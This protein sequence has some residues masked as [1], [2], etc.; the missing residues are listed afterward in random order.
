VNE[1]VIP[2]PAKINLFLE[3]VA[4][5]PDGFHEIESVLQLVDL[6]DEVRLC[7]RRDGIRLHVSGAELPEGR[8]NLAYRAA[9]AALETAGVSDGVEIR[10]VKRI[11]VGG[12]LGGGSS[13]AAA[14]LLGVSRL[15]DFRW[16]HEALHRLAGDLGSDVPFFLTDGVAVARGRGE[17]LTPL[18][19]WTPQWLVLANPGISISTGWAYGE[20]SSKLTGCQA[21][22]R[23][24]T[25]TA[26]RPLAWP[27]VWAF[28]RFE[29]VVL[30]HRPE[31]AALKS[32]LEE[33]GGRPALLSGS[34]A[35]VFAIV[36]DAAAAEALAAR[37]R[38]R[39]L[40]AAAVTTLPAN[41]ML[42]A[43]A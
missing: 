40:F 9:A 24:P 20:A 41:P 26:G 22:V 11:P 2:A 28:N 14:V 34:G 43:G 13:N 38:E 39:G 25:F 1:V 18:A 33:G 12:G 31:V 30:P 35:S 5:R 4:R 19:A 3:I 15:Y 10:L 32:F 8:D 37:V 29:D 6:C 42:R 21:R 16:S 27:P 7:R 23:L 17:L 36:A